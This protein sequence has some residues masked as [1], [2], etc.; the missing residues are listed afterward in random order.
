[1]LKDTFSVARFKN[2]AKQYQLLEKC[3]PSNEFQ[4][5]PVRSSKEYLSIPHTPE[6]R[7]LNEH[8]PIFF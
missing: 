5:Y 6:E 7:K 2:K 8:H 3:L 4:Q 1:M